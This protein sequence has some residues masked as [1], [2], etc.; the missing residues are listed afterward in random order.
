MSNSVM[1]QVRL[2]Y[3]HPYGHPTVPYVCEG[4][5]GQAGEVIT[6]LFECGARLVASGYAEAVTRELHPIEVDPMPLE[7][8]QE[9]EE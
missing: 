4:P 1:M 2:L 9:D 8:Q 3:D 6:V 5:E 7:A